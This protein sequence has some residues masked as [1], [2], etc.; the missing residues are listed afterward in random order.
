MHHGKSEFDL[1]KEIERVCAEEKLGETDEFPDGK[2]T[3]DDEGGIKIG[4]T[5]KDGNV[6][7][8]FGKSVSWLGFDPKTARQLAEMLRQASYKV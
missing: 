2:I 3:E 6:I 7:L 5:I 1:Q 4:V 8:V